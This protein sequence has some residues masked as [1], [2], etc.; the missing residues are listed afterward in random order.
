MIR[1]KTWLAG[2]YE[3]ITLAGQGGM[4]T[5]WKGR[6]H[7]EGGF[8][9]PVAIKRMLP[10]LGD[11]LDF[12]EMFVEEARVISDLQHPNIV[13]FHDFVKDH[14]DN[15]VIVMEW[16]EGI[17]L[18]SFVHA[19]RG[20]AR[21]TPWRALASAAAQTLRALHAAHSRKTA[22][23]EASPIFHRD[24]TPS[25]ILITPYGV[26]K[27]AD[28]GLARAM[29]RVTITSPGVLKGKLAYVAPEL[30]GGA[31]A[32]AQSD[33]YSLAVVL[34]ES[35]A[36]RR[37]FEGKNEIELFVNVGRGEIPALEE[38]REGLPP[39]LM[40][41]THRAL[42]KDLDERFG[43]AASMADAL[44]RMLKEDGSCSNETDLGDAVQEAI[45]LREGQA[46]PG[47]DRAVSD[48]SPPP[49]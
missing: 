17:D 29:D 2:R 41:I 30:I 20:A 23:G 38:E 12:A 22:Q 18:G 19:Y 44:E 31:R 27:L 15:Y 33:L 32:G 1:D 10:S 43:S 16:V 36:G 49:S 25:N 5:V 13:R 6:T 42:A 40:E 47:L 45:A 3:P 48:R 28:F 46:V 34:W 7:G 37:L 21:E 24:V 9:C 35:L 26:A 11:N 14:R 4:A 39:R 8:T